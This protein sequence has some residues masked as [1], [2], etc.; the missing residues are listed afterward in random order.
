M[1]AKN[2]IAL[3]SGALFY[4]FLYNLILSYDNK[5]AHPTFNKYII[6][7]FETNSQSYVPS[8]YEVNIS[9]ESITYNGKAVTNPGFLEISYGESDVEYTASQWIEH[10]GY[11]A[12]QPELAASVR[13]FYDPV[14]LNAGKKHL[15]NRGT[16]WEGVYPNPETDA[17]EWAMGDTPKGS[18]NIWSLERGKKFL[19]YAYELA[20]VNL[21]NN[22]IAKAYRSLGEVLHNTCDMGCPPHTRNDSHAAPIGYSGGYVFGSPDAYEELF[23]PTWISQYMYGNVDPDLKSFID[24]AVSIRSINEKLA[25][26]TN[27]NFFTGQ[28]INGFSYKSIFPINDDGTYASPLLQNLDYDELSMTYSKT[29]PSGNK[30]M[31]AKD[32]GYFGR[33]YPFIDRECVQSQSSELI[34]NIIYAGANLMKLFLPHL[35][36]IISSIDTDGRIIGE[37]KHIPTFEYSTAFYYSGNVEIYNSKDS[38]KIGTVI[39]ENGDINQVLSDINI[40]DEVY[41][42][43]D[44]AGIK[45]RSDI[46]KKVK[47]DLDFSQ[48]YIDLHIKGFHIRTT[49]DSSYEDPYYEF[50]N[51]Y[52]P[53]GQYGN[54]SGTTF[55]SS[56]S[57]SR[58][59]DFPDAGTMVTW[60]GS[61]NII[62]SEDFKEI[63]SYTE[64]NSENWPGWRTTNLSASVKNIPFN[65]GDE[66]SGYEYYLSMDE[67]TCNYVVSRTNNT[68]WYDGK[69]FVFSRNECDE[70]SYIKI[71]LYK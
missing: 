63:I 3:L 30:V 16:L 65:F 50:Y 51:T 42:L 19:K 53:G 1:K 29:F 15:T 35:K 4:I 28:T 60:N 46:Y 54:L 66:W 56:W 52:S 18:E 14:G 32:K 36:I 34:P 40:D 26:F 61:I 38:K 71:T 27:K 8:E 70:E 68:T 48:A 9:S 39:C 6:Q 11:S 12:D 7:F 5:I 45:I 21:K 41:G 17:I 55:T 67:E 43:I 58:E 69:S 31:M 23:N 10:G 22:N 37:V 2:I 44:L 62:F 57:D 64:I 59:E 33:T 20:D 47:V 25:E 49:A 24:N 13:H